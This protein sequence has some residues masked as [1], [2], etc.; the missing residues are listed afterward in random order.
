MQSVRAGAVQ[1]HF[2]VFTLSSKN[3]SPKTSF[4]VHFWTIFITNQNLE[5]KEGFKKVF[6]KRCPPDSNRGLWPWPGAPWQ[7][8]SCARCLN[9]KQLFEQETTTWAHFWVRF[10]ALFLE[11]VISES[12]FEKMWIFSWNLKPSLFSYCLFPKACD[13]TRSGPRLPYLIL[14]YIYNIYIYI[15]VEAGSLGNVWFI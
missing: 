6:K 11:W 12:M 1:T 5:W 7:P 15:Y 4:W 8:P 14:L 2:F 3:S 10:W 9:K 13:L